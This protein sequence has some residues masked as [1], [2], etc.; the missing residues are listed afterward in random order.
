[1]YGYIV[2][3]VKKISYK[4][5]GKESRKIRR[6]GWINKDILEGIDEKKNAYQKWLS[7][8]KEEDKNKYEQKK[9]EV[10]KE[11]RQAKNEMWEKV[12]ADINSKLGCK[13]SAAAWSV[14]RGLKRNEDHKTRIELITIN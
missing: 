13:Q 6:N 4:V 11:V 2:N 12:C 8:S 3:T 10:R 5:L 1:M 14:L 9:H 7:S